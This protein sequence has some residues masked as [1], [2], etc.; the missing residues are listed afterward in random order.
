MALWKE[1]AGYEGLY[2]ISNE[3]EVLS[4]PKVINSK[5]KFGEITVKRKAK[6]LKPHLR[7]REYAQYPAVTLVKDGKAKTYSLHRLLA[8]AFIPNPNNLPVV[9]HKDENPL[10]YSLDNLEWC[11]QQYNV[12][13]SKSRRVAQYLD[14]EKIAEYKS[15]NYAAKMTGILRSSIGNCLCGFSNAAGGYTW[16]Y[17]DRKE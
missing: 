2:L 8:E 7:G 4:L 9:N 15:I 12:D 16:E 10:N 1:I 5:N 17:C 13:Y 6:K 3:G 11:T 14:G